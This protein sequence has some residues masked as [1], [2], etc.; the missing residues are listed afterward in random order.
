MTAEHVH[1]GAPEREF[2]RLGV[3]P[4]PVTDFSVNVSPLGPP[5]ELTDA[6]GALAPEVERY[7]T[8][9]GSGVLAYCRERLG[10]A[11]ECVLAGNGSAEILY[12]VPR[13]LGLRR[14]A[15]LSPS[16]H[17]Y[18][19]AAGL[20][21][22]AVERI[23]LSPDRGFA[24][25]PRGEVAAALA[26]ADALLIGNP[27]NPT[28]TVAEPETLLGLA[29]E[30]QDKWLVVDEAFVQF[31]DSWPDASL[32]RPDRLRANVIVTQS[33]TKFYCV[34][35]LRI[36]YA[37]GAPATMARLRKHKE[38]WTVNRVA[39]AA[40]GILAGCRG[41]EEELRALV[42]SERRRVADRARRVAGIEIIEPSA[43][44]VL[45]RWRAT[46]DL[47]DL[48]RPLLASGF[49]VRDCRNFPHLEQGWFRFALRRSEENDRLLDA[50]ER[51]AGGAGA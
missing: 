6:W 7:P 41:Y 50:I 22:A 4:R 21:G 29:D 38:P 47:D 19:R 35:G 9:E 44:F 42:G 28:G 25:P 5:H 39:E 45:A 1:G 34:P 37:V 27:N 18:E 51:A 30:F 49:H 2:V 15:V 43:N 16:F 26:R 13:A 20:A 36:G 24:F 11:E 46:D 10:L 14:V 17:D 48:L 23:A 12:L 32:A 33:L 8:V 40:A 31:L 3:E